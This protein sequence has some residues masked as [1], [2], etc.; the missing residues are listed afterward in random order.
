MWHADV[1][2]SILTFRS[3]SCLWIKKERKEVPC[4]KVSTFSITCAH[5]YYLHFRNRVILAMCDSC[6]HYIEH[7]VPRVV[8]SGLSA[9]PCPQYLHN[10]R[11]PSASISYSNHFQISEHNFFLFSGFLYVCQPL[12][13]PSVSSEAR[14]FKAVV[15]LQKSLI[16]LPDCSHY[17]TPIVFYIFRGEVF[18]L[19]IFS[20]RYCT[21]SQERK[22]YDKPVS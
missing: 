14:T 4:L 12:W 20:A 9:S 3:N 22:N 2:A 11:H 7:T 5:K 13:I 10:S 8:L 17:W 21:K 16:S 1:L 19:F 15:S 18:L 6:I